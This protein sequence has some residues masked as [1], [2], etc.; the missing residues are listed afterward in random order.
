MTNIKGI[1]DISDIGTNEGVQTAADT[2]TGKY[3]SLPTKSNDKT[4]INRLFGG[5]KKKLLE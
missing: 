2:T 3:T 4:R 5:S 1:T